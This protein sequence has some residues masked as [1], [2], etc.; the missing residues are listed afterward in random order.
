M[1]GI[2]LK[3]RQLLTA[4]ICFENDLGRDELSEICG[5][6][7]EFQAKALMET[8]RKMTLFQCRSAVLTCAETA[9]ELNSSPDPESRLIELIA[10]LALK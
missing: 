3:M 10:R 2:S 9:Y 5:L 8:S 7:F 4:R 1:F 6:R